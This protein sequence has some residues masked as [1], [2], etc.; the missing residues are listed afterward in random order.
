[1]HMAVDRAGDDV[2]AGGIYHL[3][4]WRHGLLGADRDDGFAADRHASG[5]GRVRRYHLSVFDQDVCL[6]HDSLACL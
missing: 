4:G 6:L 5:Y 2:F 1:M 3:P